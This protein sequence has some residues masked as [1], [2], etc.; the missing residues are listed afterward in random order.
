MIGA[1]LRP[2]RNAF[3][4]RY[5]SATLVSHLGSM[6]QTVAATW[7]M[8]D[9]TRSAS[10]V[11]LVQ[12]SSALPI[13][14][15]AIVA[16]TLGDL[17]D[18][19]TVMLCAQGIMFAAALLLG[20]LALSGKVTAAWV[21]GL[22]LLAGAGAALHGPASQAALRD[23]VPVEDLPAA[24]ALNSIGYNLA[25]CAGPAIAGGL[26]LI[27]VPAA[28]FFVNCATFAGLVILLWGWRPQRAEPTRISITRAL[29]DAFAQ[30]KTNLQIRAILVRGC[31][32][33]ILAS[34]LFS[35]LPLLAKD[36][37]QGDSA[38]YGLLLGSFGG[39]AILGGALVTWQRGTSREMI[40]RV[41]SMGFG[42]ACLVCAVSTNV[43]VSAA[44][45][46]LAGGCW[47]AV[48]ATLSLSV[49]YSSALPLLGRSLALHQTATFGGLALGGLGWGF[50]ADTWSLEFALAIS[51]AMLFLSCLLGL[52]WRLGNNAGLQ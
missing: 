29:G 13:M 39:G 22:T 37:L 18:R 36:V 9:L 27:V 5:W 11:A 25:R 32:F 4:L 10:L 40:V 23:M 41:S 26:L 20:L 15:L 51:G 19:R 8:T 6:G 24:I 1:P 12:S 38:I 7:L 17:F 52:V 46:L 16:G 2:F 33:G 3:Y 44:S 43:I 47:V 28:A 14:F 21:L 31:V 50:M 42:T 35:M 30:L 34:S 45:V 49:Q 48:V